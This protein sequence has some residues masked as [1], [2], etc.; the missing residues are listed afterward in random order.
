MNCHLVP[1]VPCG[2]HTRI[3]SGQSM[4]F[5]SWF[6]GRYLHTRVV[7]DRAFSCTRTKLF[8]K[9]ILPR[10]RVFD[11]WCHPACLTSW[12]NPTHTMTLGCLPAC[13]LR[14]G[15]HPSVWCNLNLDSSVE[16]HHHKW[17]MSQTRWH[18]AHCRQRQWC[19]KFCRP[20][21]MIS[22]SEKPPGECTYWQ[23]TSSAT[24]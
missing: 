9:W 8:W 15:V 5:T 1:Y 19:T 7:W 20:A 22:Y 6:S 3:L 21:K 2:V 24:N 17:G 18:F 16:T 12:W 13:R 23:A 4:T 11:A 10:V 14:H